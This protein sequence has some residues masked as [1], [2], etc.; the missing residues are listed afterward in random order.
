[1]RLIKILGIP[2]FA[3]AAYLA[4]GP[5]NSYSQ[6]PPAPLANASIGAQVLGRVSIQ[7]DF[8]VSLYGYF[9]F[10]SGVPGPIFSG[11]PSENTAMLTY[12]A[13]PTG[14]TLL[15]N[16][17]ILQGLE[18]PVNGQYTILNVY[19]NPNPGPRNLLTP[20]DFKQGQLVAQFRSR[21]AVVNVASPGSFQATA[22][23][24]LDSSS[25]FTINGS[26]FNIANVTNGMSIALFGPAPSLTSIAQGLL[27]DGS[28]SIHLAG[29]AYIATT[30]G[31]VTADTR[32]AQ[33]AQPRR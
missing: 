22:G 29:T 3:V 23:I 10:M 14:A 25:D 7:P 17:D 31:I 21:A 12:W 19:Y 11:D 27:T 24:V 33:D 30:A 5:Q 28:F 2:F 32:K 13:E 16:G 20:D 9:T 6:A 4:T 15:H 18:K 8:S 26:T 1:M